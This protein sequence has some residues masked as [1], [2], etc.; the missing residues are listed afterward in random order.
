MS[1]V[2]ALCY[3]DLT[4]RVPASSMR[5]YAEANNQLIKAAN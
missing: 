2:M 3:P 4:S 5:K 1:L